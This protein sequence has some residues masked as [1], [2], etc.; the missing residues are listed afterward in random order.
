[1]ASPPLHQSSVD[2]YRTYPGMF[3]PQPIGLRHQQPTRSPT[4]L[5]AETLALSR[6]NWNQ[7]RLDGKLPVTLRTAE[8]VKRILRFCDPDQSVATRYAYYM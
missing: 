8:Q 3:V 6:M 5:A 4:E 7:T 2:F 1:M